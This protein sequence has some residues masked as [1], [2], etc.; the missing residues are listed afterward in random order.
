MPESRTSFAVLLLAL[1][2]TA[3]TCTAPRPL[4]VALAT[5]MRRGWP[6]V[7]V[8]VERPDGRV[9]I[10]A[11]GLASIEANTPMT[12]TTGFH[13]CSINKTF[14]AVAI[15]RLVEQGK[16]SLDTKVTDILDQPVVKRIPHIND[17]TVAQLL[18]HSS[19]VYA[20]NNDA[21]YLNTLIGSDAFT[22]RVWTPEEM[23]ELATR[24]GNTPAGAPGEGHYYSDT[25]YILLGMI[26]ER[27]SGEP[28]KQHVARTLLRPLGMDATYF[29]SDVL[30]GKRAMPS[31]VASG[32]ITLT[33]HLTDA[34]T[35]NRL[36]TSPRTGWLNT[37][38]AAERI[39]AA[40]SLVTTLPD[41]QKFASAL[42]RGK[43]LSPAS[44]SVLTAVAS[45]MTNVEIGK[46]KTR[47][48]QG[49]MTKFGLVLYKEG[50]GPGGFNTLMAFHPK[51]GLIFIGFTNEFGRFDEVDALMTEVMSITVAA[52]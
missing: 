25:N 52:K 47:T 48:L 24:P 29:H 6:G 3:A 7:A 45:E 10:A 44:Q 31:T 12:P 39:D 49:A 23:I 28:L 5:V 17:I 42:F 51:T 18:D 46:T 2:T 4:D 16:L 32:Y 1:S 41:L 15:L 19:G 26:I 11:A 37:S 8:L 43:L 50:D 20:T 40:G 33:K 21:A 9:E 13:M 27:V 30:Q 14:T 22:R 35:F 36:F 38:V 34:V